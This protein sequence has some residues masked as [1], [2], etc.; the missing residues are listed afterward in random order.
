MQTATIPLMRTIKNIRDFDLTNKRVLMR[1]DFNVPIRNGVITDNTRLLRTIP[2]IKYA[3][4]NDAKVILI[5]HFGRPPGRPTAQDSLEPIAD[6]L[7]TLLKKPVTFVNDCIGRKIEAEVSDMT[8][9]NVILAE[10]LR[11]YNEETQKNVGFAQSLAKLGDIYINEA[12]ANSHRDHTSMTLLPTLFDHKGIGLGLEQELNT[13]TTV[14]AHDKH[15]RLVIMGGAKLSTRVDVLH[16]IITKCDLLMIGGALANTFLAAKGNPMGRSLIEPEHMEVARDILAEA[17]VLGCRIHLPQDVMVATSLQDP[18]PPVAKRVND[19]TLNDI[20]LDIGPKTV[21]TWSSV[22]QSVAT[23][24]WTGPLGA[25]EA[26][27]FEEGTFNIANAVAHSN[28]FSLIAGKD[29]LEALKECNLLN[30]VSA[31]STA[32]AAFVEYI[33][34]R[35]LPAL[36]VLHEDVGQLEGAKLS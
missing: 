9:G 10:N 35:S 32:S 2:T 16:K 20:A 31:I 11:F 18:N 8:A 34:G 7:S 36:D 26:S 21:A 1:V 24:L 6:A 15:P 22:I 13:L 30:T 17:G 5:S 28:A 14:F 29:M 27:P 23:V 19:L 3:L 12:F 4:E 33:A 25:F